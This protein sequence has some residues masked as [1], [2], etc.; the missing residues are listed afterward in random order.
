MPESINW[1]SQRQVFFTGA[2]AGYVRRAGA[3]VRGVWA[4]GEYIKIARRCAVPRVFDCYLNCIGLIKSCCGCGERNRQ[5][6]IVTQAGW[7]LVL[8]T[9]VGCG[10]RYY[11]TKVP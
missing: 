4:D 10:A 11:R 7:A 6:V 1:I 3:V 5:I 9:H 8:N 2:G